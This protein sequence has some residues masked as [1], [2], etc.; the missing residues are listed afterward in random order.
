MTALDW[1]DSRIS[2]KT[3]RI[4]ED[5]GRIFLPILPAHFRFRKGVE[6]GS[7]EDGEDTFLKVYKSDFLIGGFRKHPKILPDPPRFAAIEA[8][9]K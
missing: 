8:V 4:G 9:K 7:G 2:L 1:L 6:I 5:A 3:G